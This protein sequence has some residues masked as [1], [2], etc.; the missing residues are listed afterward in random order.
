LD[1]YVNRIILTKRSEKI[2]F[3]FYPKNLSMTDKRKK[4][5]DVDLKKHQKKKKKRL[6]FPQLFCW[7]TFYTLSYNIINKAAIKTQK[8][9]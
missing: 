4:K 8:Q 9:K 7:L 6:P 5:L 3:G 1:M 2:K